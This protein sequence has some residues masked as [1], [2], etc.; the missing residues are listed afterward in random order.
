MHSVVLCMEILV[1]SMPGKVVLTLLHTDASTEVVV[2]EMVA[3]VVLVWCRDYACCVYSPS[4]M[5]LQIEVRRWKNHYY[6]H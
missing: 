1:D 2:G 6:H 3:V 4:M 5:L